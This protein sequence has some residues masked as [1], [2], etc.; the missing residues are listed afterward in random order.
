MVTGYFREAAETLNLADHMYEVLETSYRETDVQVPVHRDNGSVSVFRGYRVQHNG[1]RG[2]YK[3]GIRYHPAVDIAEVRALASLMTW[4]TALFNLPFGGAKGG[5][6]VDPAELSERELEAL[7]RRF[8]SSIA[9]VLGPY[10]DVPAPDMNTNPQVM[11]WM[12][13]AYSAKN[14]YT[15]AIVTG[16]PLA[17]GGAP[18]RTEA[19]GRGV[20]YA[21]ERALER[22]GRDLTGLRVAIQGFGNVGTHAA[23][24]VRDLG[25]TVVAISDIGGGIRRD[26]G[27]NLEEATALVASGS[28]VTNSTDVD[29]LDAGEVLTTDCDVLIPAALGEV[30]SDVN[31]NDIKAEWIVEGA[32][33]P[34]TPNADKLLHENGV[35][36]VPDILANGGGVT[37]SYFEWTQNIQQF[38][39]AEADFNERLRTRMREAVD[40]TFDAAEKWDVRPRRAAFAIAIE[41]VA[42]A[43]HMRGYV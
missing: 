40:A 31:V 32:N 29:V 42:D 7:T 36:I 10:R 15:P 17:F 9:H 20:A 24:T 37:G 8:T 1:A 5:V 35:K 6:N 19:T 26:D 2:P 22:N 39:W 27:I 16:K 3:G 21:L 11:A 33:N 34:T 25:A 38:T 30:I 14:G 13:D 18:G 12:M 23:Y 28:S 43:A 41:R 4:K